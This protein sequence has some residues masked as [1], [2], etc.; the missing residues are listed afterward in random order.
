MYGFSRVRIELPRHPLGLG[1]SDVFNR[2]STCERAVRVWLSSCCTTSVFSAASTSPRKETSLLYARRTLDEL[3]SARS[4]TRA[5]F[6]A[7]SLFATLRSP[8]T[9][10][11]APR[12]MF[13]RLATRSSARQSLRTLPA[14]ARGYASAAEVGGPSFELTE[15]QAGIRELTRN[16]TVSA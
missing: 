10:P 1:C 6:S 7:D 4:T 12:E 15:E 11:R 13:A 3:R 9:T 14:Q 2:R 5:L 8:T 16:F